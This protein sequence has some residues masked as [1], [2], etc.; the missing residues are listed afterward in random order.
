MFLKDVLADPSKH[1]CG[2]RGPRVEGEWK[3]ETPGPPL[4][5]RTPG[6]L[7]GIVFCPCLGLSL[8]GCPWWVLHY[9][10]RGFQG[11]E[12]RFI[13]LCLANSLSPASLPRHQESQKLKPE[14]L[15]FLSEEG[16]LQQMPV[17]LSLGKP[18]QEVGWGHQ[19]LGFLH[20][21]PRG[22]AEKEGRALF[23]RQ[24]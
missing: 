17:E 20:R 2:R 12:K 22:P 16:P 24:G 1:L 13:F 15:G 3:E 7:C 9:F 21:G 10:P 4:H 11:V 18:S 19:A 6:R 8:C 5:P 23:P 14:G